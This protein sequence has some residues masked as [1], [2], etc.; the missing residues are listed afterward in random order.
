MR[1]APVR[2]ELVNYLDVALVFACRHEA[3]AV[4]GLEN[5]DAEP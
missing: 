5:D 2:I 4:A 3:E 1:S